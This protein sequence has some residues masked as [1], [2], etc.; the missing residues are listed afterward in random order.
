MIKEIEIKDN[1]ACI[2]RGRL[3]IIEIKR[4]VYR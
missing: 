4:G 1:Q 2:K 3:I